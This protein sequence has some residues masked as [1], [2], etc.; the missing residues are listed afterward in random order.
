MKVKKS[1]EMSEL[2]ERIKDLE[3]VCEYWERSCNDWRKFYELRGVEINR[4]YKRLAEKE[5][6]NEISKN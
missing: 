5:L 4:L 6:R 1:S 2:E 3:G